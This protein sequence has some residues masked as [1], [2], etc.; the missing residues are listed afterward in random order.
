MNSN[1]D[2]LRQIVNLIAIV[3]AFGTNIIA[4]VAP[5]NGQT[6][7]EISNT[8]FRDVLVTPANYA[9][10]IWGLIYLGLI[11]FA[12]YQALPEQRRNSQL[13]RMGYLVAIASLAQITW[14]FFFLYGLFALSFVA[15][16]GILFPL[17]G[18]Y[19][20]L[21]NGDR[22]FWGQQ[23]WFV[24]VPISIYLAWISVA[25]I[26]NGAIVLDY[27]NWNGWGIDPQIWTAIVL[28]VATVIA[29]TVSIRR[30]D[31]VY[32]GVFVWAF[33]AIAVRNSNNLVIAATA[34]GLAIVLV[35]I[36]MFSRMRRYLSSGGKIKSSRSN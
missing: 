34:G 22:S 9:F 32:M 36:G 14:I 26:V 18:A 16:L 20:S 6:I 1:R 21:R 7:G 15:M 8:L 35:L 31:L 19:Q 17:I 29:A 28:L 25:T 33:V 23:K 12:I 13:Q 27:W 5:F 4:N 2:K 24:Y 11:S 10:A 3:A 30:D